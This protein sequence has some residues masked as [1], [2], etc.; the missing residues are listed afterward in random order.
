MTTIVVGRGPSMNLQEK[1]MLNLLRRGKDHYGF[2]HVRAE[3][4]AEGVRK[5]ELSRL[6]ELGYKAGLDL[7]IK[8]AGCEAMSDMHYAKQVGVSSIIAPMIESSYALKKYAQACQKVFPPSEQH[9][10]KF[11]FNIE[12]DQAFN[13]Q[14]ELIS[15]SQICGLE[16]IVFGRV[17]FSASLGL[18]R[19]NI[20]SS[21]MAEKIIK[22]AE[23]CKLHKQELIVGGGISTRSIPILNQIA[24]VHLSRFE[25]RKIAFE[26]TAL[27]LS[28][29]IQGLTEA[30]HFELLWLKNK[31]HYYN[32]LKN[33]DVNRIQLLEKRILSLVA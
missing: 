22:T 6:I 21:F 29:L 28:T 12:T 13:N 10:T 26:S 33:E 32:S 3:F 1:E 14:K 4:E 31:Q 19:D 15:T 11:Y 30:A 27:H 16:G 23:L 18:T 24:R 9:D 8:V 20:E 7:I 17:D 2:T 5:E 25:T